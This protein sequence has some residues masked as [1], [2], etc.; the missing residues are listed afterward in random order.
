MAGDIFQNGEYLI[1]DETPY[2]QKKGWNG[3]KVY[4][5]AY[6]R[7]NKVDVVIGML[8]VSLKE[9]REKLEKE[10]QIKDVEYYMIYDML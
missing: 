6:I 1:L 2:L 4:S 5:P 9:M 7:E 3:R 8:R 10:Y